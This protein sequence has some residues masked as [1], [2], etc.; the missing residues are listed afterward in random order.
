MKYEWKKSEREI[1]LPKEKPQLINIPS[2]KY[3][4]IEGEGNPN[5]EFFA[6]YIGVLYSLSYAVRMSYKS[7]IVPPGYYEYTVYPLEGEWDISEEARKNY[8]GVL[9]KNTLVFNLMIRQP[10]FVDDNYAQKII[11]Q[12]KKK[13]PS[14]L[15]DKIKF[16][17][18]EE[19]LCV[20]MLHVGSYDSEPKSFQIMEEFCAKNNIERNSMKHREIY[21]SDPRK[22]KPEKLKTALRFRVN[23]NGR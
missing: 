8:D 17:A 14:K 7:G 10:E 20:Q 11:E 4:S 19:G 13:K 12:T 1:Y 6:E 3:F 2:F 21:L 5:D 9:D 18:Y 15:L 16:V 23:K 22:V